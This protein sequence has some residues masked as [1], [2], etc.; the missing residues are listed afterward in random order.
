MEF[1]ALDNI[2]IGVNMDLASIL[3]IDEAI[4]LHK[5]HYWI[6]VNEKKGI[7]YKEGRYWTFNS[8]K[9][10]KK[11]SLHFGVRARLREFL[12]LWRIGEF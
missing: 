8:L 12:R 5:I 3:G 7:N 9:N 4:V 1:N 11:I 6:N 10:G 2:Q